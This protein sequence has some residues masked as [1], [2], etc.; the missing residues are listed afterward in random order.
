MQPST[1][2]PM[3]PEAM[4]AAWAPPDGIWS[5]WARPVLFAQMAPEAIA[6]ELPPMPDIEWAPASAH[7]T[8]LVVDLPSEESVQTGLALAAR[9]YRPV[10]LFNGCT[11][12]GEVVDQQGILRA[13]AAGA[14]HLTSQQFAL[15][16]PPAFLLDALRLRVAPGKSLSP[17]AFDNRWIVFPQDF[18][19]ARFLIGRGVTQALLVQRGQRE[20]EDDLAHV[21][22]RWQD[23][24]IEIHAIDLADARPAAKITVARPRSY[25]AISY[26][27][28]AALGLRRAGRGGFGGVVPEPSHG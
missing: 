6:P 26:R 10:P 2:G 27:A 14:R 24:K 28:D 23:A 11:G 7:K 8:A 16:A 1:E 12:A 18:P 3:T 5:L 21:L 9:G 4:F 20:S 25:R 13:L 22:R 15:D 17:G 19:S